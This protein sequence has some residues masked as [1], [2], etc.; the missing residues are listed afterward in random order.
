MLFSINMFVVK[1]GA[2]LAMSNS[3]YVEQ[4]WWPLRVRDSGILL[5]PLTSKKA[6]VCDCK[7]TLS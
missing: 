3:R 1:F 4:I 5:Q 7:C 2:T 6:I